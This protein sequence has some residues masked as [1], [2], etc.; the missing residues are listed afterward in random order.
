MITTVFVFLLG[1]FQ[2][3]GQVSWN[4]AVGAGISTSFP[5]DNYSNGNK[6][7]ISP[8]I[9]LYPSV[10]FK[11]KLRITTGVEMLSTGNYSVYDNENQSNGFK[12]YSKSTTKINKLN[13]PIMVGWDLYLKRLAISPYA[14]VNLNYNLNGVQT[15]ITEQSKGEIS[16]KTRTEDLYTLDTEDTWKNV[17]L[18]K[19]IGVKFIYKGMVELDLSYSIGSLYYRSYLDYSRFGIIDCWCGPFESYQNNDL[20]VVIKYSLF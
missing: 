16:E 18:Q 17:L 9:G 10:L 3:D 6:G 15:F 20:K 5:S 2:L 12:Y 13:T 14:G 4:V 19:T 1:F 11:N 7:Y 8:V